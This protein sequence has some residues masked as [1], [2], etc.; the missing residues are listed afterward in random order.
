MKA[1]GAEST[2]EKPERRDADDANAREIQKR[3]RLM[4]TK[5]PASTP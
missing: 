5:R 4:T 2:E 3:R 1:N